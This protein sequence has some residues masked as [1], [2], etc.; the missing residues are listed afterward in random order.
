M[1]EPSIDD[2]VNRLVELDDSLNAIK[3]TK[4]SIDEEIKNLEEDL[5]NFS[6]SNKVPI[7]S[8]TKGQYNM[9]PTTGRKL[10]IKK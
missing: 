10:K 5:I 3:S 7:D 4:K 2:I 6:E 8:L 9:K 1:P